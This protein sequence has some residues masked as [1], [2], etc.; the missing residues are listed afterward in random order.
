VS[1][2]ISKSVVALPMHPYLDA[3]T[4]DIIVAAVLQSVGKD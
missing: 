4:Q 3:A 1:K 2:K